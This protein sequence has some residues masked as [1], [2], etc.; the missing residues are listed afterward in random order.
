MKRLLRFTVNGHSHAL[1]TSADRPLLAVLRTDL[2][3]TGTKYGCGQGLCGSC[4]VLVDGKAR[5]SCSL[6][7]ATVE[8][9]DVT[10]IEG[11]AA[12]GVLHPLQ[13]AFAQ[14]GGLQCGFCTP[15][16]IMNAAALLL[17]KPS[18][19]HDEIIQ[20]MEGNLCRCGTHVRIVRAIEK[21]ATAVEGTR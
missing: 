13:R 1:D 15:G 2:G 16:M 19:S 6:T 8:G 5:R 14:E 21:A 20:R 18:P 3:M 17:D 9:K 10:T 4:T 11:L 12:G 7:L